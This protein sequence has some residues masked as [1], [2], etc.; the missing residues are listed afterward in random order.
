MLQ[1]CF[2]SVRTS[3]QIHQSRL[4]ARASGAMGVVQLGCSAASSLATGAAQVQ[5]GL[6]VGTVGGFHSKTR[7]LTGRNELW[8]VGGRE[9]S[10]PTSTNQTLRICL[11]KSLNGLAILQGSACCANSEATLQ[12]ASISLL[13]SAARAKARNEADDHENSWTATPPLAGLL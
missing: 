12:A 11:D 7:T 13:R 3:P 6:A 1:Y 5:H 9:S 10:M 2:L 8:A 4:L